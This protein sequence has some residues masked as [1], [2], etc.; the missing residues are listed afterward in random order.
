[1]LTLLHRALFLV[2]SGRGWRG[3]FDVDSRIAA[4][5]GGRQQ[6]ADLGTECCGSLQPDEIC[7]RGRFRC[8]GGCRVAPELAVDPKLKPVDGATSLL[9]VIGRID[10]HH[11]AEGTQA[12]VAG[13]VA[14]PRRQELLDELCAEG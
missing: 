8:V 12:E 11:A 5:H 7:F 1:V 14:T 9:T 10:N 2:V 4:T 13:G 6:L 3:F